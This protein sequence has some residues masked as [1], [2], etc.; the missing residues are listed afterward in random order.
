MVTTA[1]IEGLIIVDVGDH[2]LVCTKDQAQLVKEIAEHM[3]RVQAQAAS[4]N[5]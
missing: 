2:L 5:T 3:Q 1:G 4:S